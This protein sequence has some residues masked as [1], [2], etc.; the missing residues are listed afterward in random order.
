[1]TAWDD[2]DED[3]NDDADDNDDRLAAVAVGAHVSRG[4]KRRGALATPALLAVKMV[5]DF[6]A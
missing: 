2:D 5:I 1:M 4:E 3:D 6:F